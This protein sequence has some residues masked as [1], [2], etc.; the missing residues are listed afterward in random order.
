MITHWCANQCPSISR[1]ASMHSTSTSIIITNVAIYRRHTR[2]IQ[3]TWL[4]RLSARV[5]VYVCAC[6]WQRG[7]SK[8]PVEFFE[9]WTFE[10]ATWNHTNVNWNV[11]PMH[12]MRANRSSGI[13]TLHFELIYWGKIKR[14]RKMQHL[15]LCRR[16]DG[17]RGS[18][19]VNRHINFQMLLFAAGLRLLVCLVTG[20]SLSL[21][22]FLSLS[23]NFHYFL[24]SSLCLACVAIR[25]ACV[26]GRVQN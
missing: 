6:V 8:L 22:P 9:V 12:E 3:H 11:W 23:H 16:L 1:I 2:Y 24:L 15:A 19:R 25:C 21:S 4:D 18:Q 5:C 10:N 17:V 26:F 20:F 14:N 13:S 7:F